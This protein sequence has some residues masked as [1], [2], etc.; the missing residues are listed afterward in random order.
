[1]RS[2]GWS[3]WPDSPPARWLLASCGDDAASRSAEPSAAPEVAVDGRA[4]DVAVNEPVED[5][6]YPDVG[7]PGVDALH[8]DLD[9]TWDPDST[10]LTG[11]ETLVFRATADAPRFQLD[12][13]APLEVS[14]VT[15]DGRSVEHRHDGKDLVVEQ[16]VRADQRYELSLDYT[17][18]PEPVDVPT[19]RADLSTTGW[20]TTPEGETWT[21][22]EPWGA[23][24]WYA[25]ND[26]PSDKALY[27][28]TLTV[29]SPWVGVA[30]GE[31]LDRTEADDRP[32]PSGTWPSPPRP[33]SSPPRSVTTR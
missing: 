5:S 12:L 29:P 13:G 10:T 6:L 2:R 7:D 1:M 33:T 17:G 25:V 4:L 14:D 20:T 19:M 28:F 30:N 24:T 8:Y 22:Q 32:R 16:P 27:D 11:E 26:H 21:M 31:L 3:S 9:L 15:V 18:T 23:Y